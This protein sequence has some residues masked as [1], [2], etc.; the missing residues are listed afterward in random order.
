MTVTQ[1]AHYFV[2]MCRSVSCTH[3]SH[4]SLQMFQIFHHHHHLHQNM[5]NA[6]EIN[7]DLPIT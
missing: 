5:K 4:C 6:Q 1:Q 3:K 2:T 7:A